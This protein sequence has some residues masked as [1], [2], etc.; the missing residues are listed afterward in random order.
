MSGPAE[1]VLESRAYY[2]PW[3]HYQN[4]KAYLMKWNL[5]KLRFNGIAILKIVLDSK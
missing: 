3:H 2:D 5:S 4:R 1:S